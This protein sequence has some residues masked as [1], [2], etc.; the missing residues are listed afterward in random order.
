MIL[1]IREHA[2]KFAPKLEANIGLEKFITTYSGLTED[3]KSAFA[4]SAYSASNLDFSAMMQLPVDERPKVSLLLVVTFM[5]YEEIKR[6]AHSQN[7]CLK[8]FS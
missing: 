5:L 7:Q 4:L 3:M 8:G 2:S 6:N 1:Q